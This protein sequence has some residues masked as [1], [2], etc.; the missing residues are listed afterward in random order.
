MKYFLNVFYS[1]GVP[2]LKIK[3]SYDLSI[4]LLGIHPNEMES[5]TQRQNHDPIMLRSTSALFT[6]AM[7][8]KQPKCPLVEEWIKL[9]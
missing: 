4:S 7:A 3:L 9:L 8:W 5:V 1:L 6:I 2:P